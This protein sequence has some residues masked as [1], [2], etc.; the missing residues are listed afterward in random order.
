MNYFEICAAASRPNFITSVNICYFPI[1]FS[2]ILNLTMTESVSPYI[3]SA[4]NL[5]IT[6]FLV[7]S[8]IC[9]PKEVTDED[10]SKQGSWPTK[11]PVKP[12]TEFALIFKANCLPSKTFCN[13]GSVV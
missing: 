13:R 5:F 11:A 2:G 3:T 1:I 4:S 7:R 8:I 6:K 12:Y 10:I 9:R